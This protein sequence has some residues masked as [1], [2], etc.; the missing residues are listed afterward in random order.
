MKTNAEL[1]ME[2]CTMQEQTD[3]LIFKKTRMVAAP[4]IENYILAVVD[5]IGELNHELKPRWCWWKAQPGEVDWD[6]TLAELVDIWHFCISL[7]IHRTNVDPKEIVEVLDFERSAL[8]CP[9]ELLGNFASGWVGKSNLLSSF[10]TLI[11]WGNSFG[12]DF[13]MIY[14]A[15]KTKN[16]E[17]N[18]R[19]ESDY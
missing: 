16:K 1:F 14:E 7:M 3:Q 12:L 5:E 15:Y 11:G 2:M 4:S 10:N 6:R 18:E 8:Y 9:V 17:N 19:A 13:P